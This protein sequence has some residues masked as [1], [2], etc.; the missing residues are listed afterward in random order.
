M[1]LRQ[2]NIRAATSLFFAV[3][4]DLGLGRGLV[5]AIGGLYVAFAG[6][7]NHQ[8]TGNCSPNLAF[9]HEAAPPRGRH[10]CTRN[11]RYGN[12]AQVRF[13]YHNM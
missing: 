12:F 1:P 9:R 7:I 11:S 13:D 8:A 4:R 3:G 10:A 6:G 5:R 2:V